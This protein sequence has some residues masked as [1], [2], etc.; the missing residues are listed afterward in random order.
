[1]AQFV[2]P[3][4]TIPSTIPCPAGV[5]QSKNPSDAGD[6]FISFIA[7]RFPGIFV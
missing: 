2:V 7:E 6:S 1:M 5:N 3:M 4:L